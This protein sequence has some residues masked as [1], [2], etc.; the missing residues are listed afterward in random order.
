MGAKGRQAGSARQAGPVCWH[1][2][3]VPAAP[4]LP[5]PPHPPWLLGSSRVLHPLRSLPFP[6]Q[7]VLVVP[8]ILHEVGTG[9][10]HS[11][12]PIE[13]YVMATG[14][15]VWGDSDATCLLDSASAVP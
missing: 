11:P 15:G 8:S 2:A 1:F 7:D 12:V 13:L 4:F 6:S 5:V 3:F 9:P 10:G 14:G